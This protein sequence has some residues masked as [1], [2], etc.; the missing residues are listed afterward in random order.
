MVKN[1]DKELKKGKTICGNEARNNKMRNKW[2]KA[3]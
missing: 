3:Y 2:L 1:A